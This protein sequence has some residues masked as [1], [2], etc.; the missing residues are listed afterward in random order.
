ML[1]ELSNIIA[2]DNLKIFRLPHRA[3]VSLRKFDFSLC[4]WSSEHI[5]SVFYASLYFIKA[6]KAVSLS[7]LSLKCI[8]QMLHEG[9][10]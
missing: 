4:R 5:I 3:G 6:K 2:T 8:I 7:I 9:N 1:A 10:K